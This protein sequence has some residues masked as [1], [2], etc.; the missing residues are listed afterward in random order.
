MISGEEVTTRH[1][2]W[3]AVGLP[4]GAWV[5]WRYGPRDGVFP[6]FAGEVRDT[7]GLVV[8][9]HPSAPVP[10]S[11]WEFGFD[12]VDG[13]EVWNGRWNLDDEVSLRIWQRLLC[14]GR[15]VVAVGGSDSHG[16]HQVVGSPH[17]GGARAPS[18]RSPPIDRT[19]WRPAAAPTS[20]GSPRGRVRADRDAARTAA[21]A[22]WPGPGR[23]LRV[24]ARD[25]AA[26]VTAVISGAP[27]TTAA[28]IT[29]AGRVGHA[30]V[31]GPARTMARW[32]LDAASDRCARLEIREAQRRPLGA[33]VALQASPDSDDGQ[34]VVN[35]RE[36]GFIAG[37]ERDAQRDGD[38]RNEEIERG[39]GSRPGSN[40]AQAPVDR[41]RG[42]E[43]N[44]IEGW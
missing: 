34:T 15:R 24:L 22:R 8:A 11:V 1:G 29:A 19:G 43:R 25:A 30:N 31:R 2:H 37:N 3:L 18:C 33:M 14:E 10:G 7:G 35:T 6:R 20:S 42:I 4:P 26:T 9:A 17:D 39:L 21:P 13:L 40:V 16:K 5:D 12:H 32:E 38:R 44:R 28:L 36:I 27:G 41:R 23:Q